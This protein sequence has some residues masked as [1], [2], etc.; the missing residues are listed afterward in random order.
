MPDEKEKINEIVSQVFDSIEKDGGLKDYAHILYLITAV[1]NSVELVFQ[2]KETA[3]K[4]KL[5]SDIYIT[6]IDRLKTENKIHGV[7]LLVLEHIPLI[8]IIEYIEVL[9]SHFLWKKTPSLENATLKDVSA[10]H[11]S[12]LK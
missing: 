8:K 11:A 2:I 5:V 10:N 1:M 12:G 9:A 6:V 4:E 7:S 3:D